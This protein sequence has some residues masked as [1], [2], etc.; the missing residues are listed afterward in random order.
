MKSNGEYRYCKMSVKLSY[1]LHLTYESSPVIATESC[2]LYI[3]EARALLHE[4]AHTAPRSK[5]CFLLIAKAVVR[6]AKV[7]WQRKADLPA[8][9]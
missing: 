6:R 9:Y 2:N 4:S 5:I 1:H 3:V 8:G 7:P